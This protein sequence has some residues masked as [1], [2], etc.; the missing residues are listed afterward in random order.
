MSKY[1]NDPREDV[2]R[3]DS[4]VGYY[5]EEDKREERKMAKIGASGALK[6]WIYATYLLTNI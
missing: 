3:T 4:G 6:C 5:L 2:L 1:L